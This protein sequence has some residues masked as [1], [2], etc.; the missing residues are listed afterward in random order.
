MYAYLHVVVTCVLRGLRTEWNV[1]CDCLS[2]PVTTSSIHYG[3]LNNMLYCCLW[4]I[5]CNQLWEILASFGA[6]FFHL[7]CVRIWTMHDD[8]WIENKTTQNWVKAFPFYFTCHIQRWESRC[9]HFVTLYSYFKCGHKL[10]YMPDVSQTESE[11]SLNVI[12]I[13]SRLKSTGSRRCSEIRSRS[14]LHEFLRK[15]W[16]TSQDKHVIS[17]VCPGFYSSFRRDTCNFDLHLLSGNR[18]FRWSDRCLTSVVSDFKQ[19]FS[20]HR[21]QF[22]PLADRSNS[23]RRRCEKS[24]ISGRSSHVVGLP[25][26]IISHGNSSNH[27][28]RSQIT[29]V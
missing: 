1:C 27:R 25:V 18:L 21:G 11:T 15:Q 14:K 12:E 23:H 9:Y 2:K 4:G 29:F 5:H 28:Q 19:P 26:F 24:G 16:I 17:H 8:D 20:M 6:F 3:A 22:Q 7:S 10:P 13:L